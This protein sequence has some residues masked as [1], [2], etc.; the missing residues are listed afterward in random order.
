MLRV[1][2]KNMACG[3]KVFT[4]WIRPAPR[5][6][7]TIAEIEV[8]VCAITQI[9]ADKNEPT[10]PTAAMASTELKLT[11]PIIARSVSEMTASAIPE[12]IAGMAKEL[13]SRNVIFSFIFVILAYGYKFI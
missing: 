5:C 9:S 4:A 10:K 3:I 1:K 2:L 12:K 8:L 7:E 13:I 11:F 6:W